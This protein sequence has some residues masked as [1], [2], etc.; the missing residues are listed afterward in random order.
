MAQ[1]IKKVFIH[2]FHCMNNYGSAMMGLVALKELQK[3][4]G[5]QTEFYC[6]CNGYTSFDDIKSELNKPIN[7]SNHIAPPPFTS[8]YKWIRSLQKRR[9]LIDASEVEKYDEVII[10]GGDDLSE[11]YTTKIY[12][13]LLK[14][15]RW[16]KVTNVYLLGQSIGPFSKFKNRMVMKY[17][18]RNIPIFVRD[19]WNKAYLKEQFNLDNNVYQG[20]DLAFMDLPLQSNKSIESEMLNRYKLNPKK[21]IT[22]VI[23]GLQGKYYTDNKQAYFDNY[24]IIIKNLLN[25]FK[26]FKI[27]LLAHTFP[28][29]GNEATQINEFLKE[30]QLDKNK[31]IVPVTEKINP[32][33]ARFI[34]GKSFLTITGRMHAAISTLQM[35]TPA[36]ALSYSAKYKGVIGMNLNRN[37]LII[38]SN[39]KN[40]WNQK[41]MPALV[42]DKVDY[43]VQNYE[44]LSREISEK[45]KEQ[46]EL[47]E[48][49]F[50]T[51]TKIK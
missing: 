12:R 2:H 35:G 18:Y 51:L 47:V 19:F 13:D 3:R 15:W 14:Y 25:Q 24:K 23:S 5:E 50:D 36:I 6:Q 42:Q 44:R 32:T 28:P 9:Y 29:H 37:D 20:A 48:Q 11:Y 8:K 45:V 39:D 31:R 1:K 26:E 4:Y 21:Y 49:N 43:I 10:L 7:L 16:H 40:L 38:E 27:V 17:F 46:Q 34:L 41:Q 30:S 33:R 22:L